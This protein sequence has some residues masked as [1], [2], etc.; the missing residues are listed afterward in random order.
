M[1]NEQKQLA[2]DLTQ[3]RSARSSPSHLSELA[4]LMPRLRQCVVKLEAEMNK[5]RRLKLHA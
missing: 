3:A 2:K 4:R 1:Q 5:E